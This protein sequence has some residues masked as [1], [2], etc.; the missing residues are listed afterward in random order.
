[1]GI[2]LFF[3]AELVLVYTNAQYLYREMLGLFGC[4]FLDKPEQAHLHD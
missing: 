2:Y 4:V 3:V 1:M